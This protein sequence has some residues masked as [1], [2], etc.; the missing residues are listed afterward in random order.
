MSLC[1]CR[2][3][4]SSFVLRQRSYSVLSKSDR[5]QTFACKVRISARAK[6][7]YQQGLFTFE[8]SFKIF[9]ENFTIHYLLMTA[10][11]PIEESTDSLEVVSNIC[12]IN[13]AVIPNLFI[14]T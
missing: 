13:I 5:G 14:A 8:N 4:S 6:N 10:N 1:C 9:Q 2:Q 11:M 12:S 3:L 7:E